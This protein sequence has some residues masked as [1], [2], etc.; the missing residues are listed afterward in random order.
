MTD[1]KPIEIAAEDL[2]NF[3][4][5]ITVR[6]LGCV[7]VNESA[8]PAKL[9]YPRLKRT[10]CAG[11]GEE[12]QHREHAVAEQGM[13]DPERSLPLE[14]ERDLEDG[15]DLLLGPVLEADQVAAAK[16]GL[17]R[18]DLTRPRRG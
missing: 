18:F 15:V 1:G 16:V 12:E 13:G 4:R 8:V 2:A 5:C 10:A 3:N 14:L 11:G 17:H 9:C 7:A 6:N